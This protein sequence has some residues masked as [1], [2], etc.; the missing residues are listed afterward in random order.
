MQRVVRVWGTREFEPTVLDLLIDS[1]EGVRK[2]LPP[3]LGSEL[4]FLIDLNKTL[5]AIDAS[6]YLK[7]SH[8]EAM[9][10]IAAGDTAYMEGLPGNAGLTEKTEPASPILA[11]LS[12]PT[13]QP[14]SALHAKAATAAQVKPAAALPRA[15][16]STG[17]GRGEIILFS[18]VG[19]MIIATIA[20]I[21]WRQ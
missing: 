15:K 17:S 14:G 2:G 13:P 18:V 19:L 7:V 20:A 11:G 1:R 10:L 5:R 8:A 9:L 16:K 3:D 6:A 21:L 4:D 12:P